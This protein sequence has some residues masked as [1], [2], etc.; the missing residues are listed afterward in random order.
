M[1]FKNPSG[2]S[3]ESMCNSVGW[4]TVPL[5]SVFFFFYSTPIF[6]DWK[7]RRE[8]KF[9]FTCR[10]RNEVQHLLQSLSFFFLGP[11]KLIFSSFLLLLFPKREQKVNKRD[12]ILQNH[13]TKVDMLSSRKEQKGSLET[14][15]RSLF[16][17][18][19][20]I[21]VVKSG[22]IWRIFFFQD[23]GS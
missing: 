16:W 2:V 22:G 1:W 8:L 21:S 11:N 19:F 18:S 13:K 7:T 12:N 23:N 9:F 6:G 14:P 20:D 3:L 17:N 5:P 15:A 10:P 4:L